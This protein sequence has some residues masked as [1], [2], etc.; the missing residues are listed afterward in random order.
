MLFPASQ[1][2]CYIRVEGSCK[3]AEEQC[4]LWLANIF[5]PLKIND[6]LQIG[7]NVPILC[8]LNSLFLRKWRI[9]FVF[10]LVIQSMIPFCTLMLFCSP[11]C[12]LMSFFI[13]LEAG[14]LAQRRWEDLC[15]GN[16]LRMRLKPLWGRSW[17]SAMSWLEHENILF[18]MCLKFLVA[19]FTRFTYSLHSYKTSNQDIKGFLLLSL[20]FL[21]K[22]I[23]P[24]FYHFIFF[25]TMRVLFNPL[26]LFPLFP[27]SGNH[28]FALYG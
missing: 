10:L 25:I 9:H 11:P 14:I 6:K 18:P 26:S 22:C 3:A 12:A 1:W 8:F 17:V 15:F 5:R 27:P 28:E 4:L 21:L 23:F 7:M 16:E 2:T 19:R 13:S 24:F 20:F